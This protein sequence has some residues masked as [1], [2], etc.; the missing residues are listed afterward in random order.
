M[1]IYFQILVQFRQQQSCYEA[2]NTLICTCDWLLLQQLLS[3]VG[4]VV[5]RAKCQNKLAYKHLISQKQSWKFT[6]WSELN[7]YDRYI[8]QENPVFTKELWG[9]RIGDLQFRSLTLNYSVSNVLSWFLPVQVWCST[10]ELTLAATPWTSLKLWRRVA[11]WTPPSLHLNSWWLLLKTASTNVTQ[12]G[13]P[14]SQSG[15]CG[16]GTAQILY[17]DKG[18]NTTL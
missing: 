9:Y 14:T 8:I 4:T 11:L 13:S 6:W 2:T 12:A 18:T 16:K 3:L 5:F 15:V 1:K 17:L 7:I 10:T